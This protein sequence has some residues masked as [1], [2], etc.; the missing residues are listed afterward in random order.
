MHWGPSA[1]LD[2]DIQTAKDYPRAHRVTPLYAAPPP[3][4]SPCRYPDCVDNGPDGKCALDELRAA[5]AEPEQKTK[6]E[7]ETE[8]NIGF[9]AG[10]EKGWHYG[11]MVEN[12]ACARI[13]ERNAEICVHSLTLW[14]VLNANALAIRA[15]SNINE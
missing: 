3:A 1:K 13:V 8:Y 9:K 7:A 10:W 5:L 2:A 15:R 6:V 4:L 14:D 12:S 11:S